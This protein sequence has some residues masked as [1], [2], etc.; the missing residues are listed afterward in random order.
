MTMVDATETVDGFAERLQAAIGTTPQ[1]VVAKRAQV[2]TSV[3]HK[4]L[5]GSEPGVSSAVRLAKALG[6]NLIW[7]A[8][9]EG[10]PNA[11]AGGHVGIPIYDVRLAAG[12]A[13]FVEAAPVIGEMPFDRELLRGFG[14]ASAEG[15]AVVEADGDSMEPLI[16]DGARV[17]LD[18]RDTRLREGVFGFRLG[19]ELRIK[20]LR[21]TVEGVEI[22]S[23]NSRYEPELLTGHLT[24][25]FAVI[26]RALW[27]GS[28]L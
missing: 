16:A 18:L 6:V 14:R 15:L 22:I 13:S 4:Y 20:R 27:A 25:Q 28:L 26:G 1:A 7:L 9:G 8:T 5:R 21:R 24:E 10:S 2:S 3:L 12:A 19:D 17:V 11:E 23:D